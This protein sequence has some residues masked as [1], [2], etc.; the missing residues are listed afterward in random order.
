MGAL[1]TMNATG[2]CPHGGTATPLAGSAR[3]S[4][5]GAS[6]LTLVTQFTISGCSNTNAPCTLATFL[7]GAGR[8]QT[9][10]VPVL[11]AESPSVTAPT[12]VPAQVMDPQQQAKGQ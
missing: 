2:H 11:L 5:G 4:V 10:G 3:V 12:G 1:L 9:Q 6:V 8:V 7:A